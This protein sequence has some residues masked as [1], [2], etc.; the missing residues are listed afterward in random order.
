MHG[1]T[2]KKKL[3]PPVFEILESTDDNEP[4]YIYSS[5]FVL[6]IVK[7]LVSLTLLSLSLPIS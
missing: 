5:A 2:E 1:K 7:F 4:K 6:L 3:K